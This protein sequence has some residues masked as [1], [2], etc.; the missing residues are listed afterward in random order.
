M[1][2]ATIEIAHTYAPEVLM[3]DLQRAVYERHDVYRDRADEIIQKHSERIDEIERLGRIATFFGED[4]TRVAFIDDVA[5]QQKILREPNSVW[6]RRN[7]IYWRTTNSVKRA[8][9]AK[10]IFYES[11]F[12]Q[13]GRD[14]VA[15]IQQIDLPDGYR[16]SPDGRKLITGRGNERFSVPLQGFK[17]CEDPTFPSCQV[18]DLTWLQK[19]LT[20]APHAITILP[21]G[22]E[23]QQRGVEIL[24][25]LVGVDKDTY[26]TVFH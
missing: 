3:Y 7:S 8:T 25:D 16:L 11:D 24:A 12:E 5:E 19:R 14:M 15:Q 18:L 2:H 21:V 13:A 10:E 9:N 1:A 26:Q 4:V 6:W 23:E 17:G 20:I 22:Y